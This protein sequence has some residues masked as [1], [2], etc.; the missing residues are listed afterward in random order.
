MPDTVD[1]DDEIVVEIDSELLPLIPNFLESRRSECA[2]LERLLEAGNHDEISKLGH[3]L[4]GAGGS[5]GFDAIS[6]IGIALEHAA[7][8]RDREAMV[9]ACEMLKRYLERVVVVHV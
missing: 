3:R 4:I 9:L 1:C 6:D 7:V 5:Y 8:R 2:L